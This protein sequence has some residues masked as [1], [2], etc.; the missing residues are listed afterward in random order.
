MT[1]PFFTRERI[2]DFDIYDRNCDKVLEAAK[3]RLR[4]GHPIEFQVIPSIL[5]QKY[6]TSNLHLG[7]CWKI[8]FGLCH[9]V[10]VWPQ[11]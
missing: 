3:G 6:S 1:R 9:R 4:Q 10:P 2:S 8:Y 5:L 7:S 11:R